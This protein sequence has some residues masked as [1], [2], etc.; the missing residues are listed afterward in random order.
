V[1]AT[2]NGDPFLTVG[3]HDAGSAF[4]YAIDCTP[5]WAPAAFLE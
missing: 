4:A 3:D 5:H 1:W 2:V